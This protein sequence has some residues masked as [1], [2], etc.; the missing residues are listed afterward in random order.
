[1]AQS[2]SASRHGEE[3]PEKKEENL[4]VRQELCTDAANY[5]LGRDVF[6]DF[7]LS[8]VDFASRRRENT[9]AAAYYG[10]EKLDSLINNLFSSRSRA[11]PVLTRTKA[12][13][14]PLAWIMWCGQ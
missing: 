8:L 6:F 2:L 7:N 13:S 9:I 3:K 10:K 14:D 5:I 4:V 12:W 11:C 1:V